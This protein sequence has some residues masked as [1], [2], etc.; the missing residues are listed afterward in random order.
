MHLLISNGWMIGSVQI[1]IVAAI[2]LVIILTSFSIGR[3][4]GRSKTDVNPER[5][6]QYWGKCRVCG[7][8]AAKMCTCR[9]GPSPS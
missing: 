6:A 3:A 4:M 1:W 5:L 9:G 7:G 2:A 8:I